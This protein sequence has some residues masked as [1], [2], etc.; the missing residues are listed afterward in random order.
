MVNTSKRPLQD[1]FGTA[2]CG[3]SYHDRSRN[4]VLRTGFADADE[5]ALLQ[6]ELKDLFGTC[7]N[8]VDHCGGS[9]VG[10]TLLEAANVVVKRGN[11]RG[12]VQL[13]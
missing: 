3:R 5:V 11:R 1:E 9:D 4:E 7:S 2:T 12:K 6:I 10:L 8:R 13:H